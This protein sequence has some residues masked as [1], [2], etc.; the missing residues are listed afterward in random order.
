VVGDK[1]GADVSTVTDRADE[2]LVAPLIEDRATIDL[3]PLVSEAVVQ[4]QDPVVEFAR[5]VPPLA[6]P[7]TNN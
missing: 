2:S 6:T 4:D 3:I 7:S 1:T 5:Q